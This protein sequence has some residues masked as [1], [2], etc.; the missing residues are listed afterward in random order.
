MAPP[1][2]FGRLAGARQIAAVQRVELGV[3]QR[4]GQRVGL[5]FAQRAERA[6]EMPLHPLLAIP[7]RLTVTDHQH[8][9]RR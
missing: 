2:A 5:A 4:V 1:D 6:V 9:G 7:E 3:G 8:F